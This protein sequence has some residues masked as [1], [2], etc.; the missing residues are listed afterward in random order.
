MPKPSV[1]LS[2]EKIG[3]VGGSCVLKR[4]LKISIVMGL[5][6]TNLVNF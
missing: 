3:Y 5:K 4:E 1:H 6:G 2:H